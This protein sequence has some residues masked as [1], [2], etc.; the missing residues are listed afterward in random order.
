MDPKKQKQKSI[1]IWPKV[2]I[3][4]IYMAK[5]FIKMADKEKTFFFFFDRRADCYLFLPHWRNPSF[6]RGDHVLRLKKFHALASSAARV[7]CDSSGHRG[8]WSNEAGFLETPGIP[9]ACSPA[10]CATPLPAVLS[11]LMLNRGYS[12]TET[13]CVSKQRLNKSQKPCPVNA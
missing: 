10:A 13:S 1:R 8:K 12:A 5:V 7:V 9:D 2:F 3:M 11:H 6:I 4:L